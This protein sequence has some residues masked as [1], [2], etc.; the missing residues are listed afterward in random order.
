MSN[1]TSIA[2]GISKKGIGLE[3]L[4]DCQNIICSRDELLTKEEESLL[5][6]IKNLIAHARGKCYCDFRYDLLQALEG[7]NSVG[8][9]AIKAKY[10][11]APVYA[12]SRE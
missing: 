12:T 5:S 3:E 7:N 6:E 4:R 9:D 8:A 2:E 10:F 11:T 1:L